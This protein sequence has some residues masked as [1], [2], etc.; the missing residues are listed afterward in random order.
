[1]IRRSTWVVLLIFAL[2]V[3]GM[4][5]WQ[6][7][8]GNKAVAQPTPTFGPADMRP[9]S[10]G[11]TIVFLHVD[12]AGSKT[13]EVIRD[14]QGKWSLSVPGGQ[15]ADTAAIDSVVTQLESLAPARLLDQPPGLEA[16]G[17]DKP[18][19]HLVV[20]TDSGE[21]VTADVGGLA[22]TQTGY[23][24]KVNDNTFYVIDKGSVDAIVSLAANPPVMKTP[25][26]QPGTSSATAVP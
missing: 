21:Q 24:V 22:P 4:Y 23:Y 1:M 11:G 13:V 2:L 8:Q 14:S 20:K 5:G 15:E 17:L 9:F 7:Y 10:P 12:E 19:Y 26:A 3:A 16:M 25:A 6:R 18:V